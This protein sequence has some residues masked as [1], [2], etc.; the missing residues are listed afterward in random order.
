MNSKISQAI[1]N[2]QGVSYEMLDEDTLCIKQRVYNTKYITYI[3]PFCRSGQKNNGYKTNGE[4]LKYS[5]NKCHVI[6]NHTYDSKG[7]KDYIDIEPYACD[8]HI[9]ETYQLKNYLFRL[10]L[11]K[12]ELKFV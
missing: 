5:S 6:E 4:K 8:D 7:K 10:Y 11:D 12:P 1:E 3:C 2:I 9:K